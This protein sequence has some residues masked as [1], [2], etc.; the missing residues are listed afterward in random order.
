LSGGKRGRWTG[1]GE[2]EDF[3]KAVLMNGARK[4]LGLGGAAQSWIKGK[5]RRVV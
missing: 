3:Y 1:S 5:G 2:I 4:I